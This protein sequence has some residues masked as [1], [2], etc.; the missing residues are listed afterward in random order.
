M[1]GTA[2]PDTLASGAHLLPRP[3]GAAVV[4]ESGV[5]GLCPPARRPAEPRDDAV[6]AADAR[7]ALRDELGPLHEAITLQVRGGVVTLTG[8]T[9]FHL[10]RGGAERALRFVPG[11]CG[12]DNRIQVVAMVDPPAVRAQVLDALRARAAETA[13]R[14]EVLTQGGTVVLRGTVATAADRQAVE[15][16]AWKVPGVSAVR[17][18]VTVPP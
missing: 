17:N 8:T 7:R 4:F 3:A 18:E 16:G 11:V 14:V 15:K 1:T 12:V 5:T 13:Q 10:H 9:T 6:V 2:T